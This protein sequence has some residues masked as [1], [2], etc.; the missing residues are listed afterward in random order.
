MPQQRVFEAEVVLCETA[1][2]DRTY[3]RYLSLLLND[4][5]APNDGRTELSASSKESCHGWH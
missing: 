4:P 2:D 5:L 3:S 1:H